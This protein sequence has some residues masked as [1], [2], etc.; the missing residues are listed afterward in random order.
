MVAIIGAVAVAR[1]HHKSDA[2]RQG[3]SSMDAAHKP[4]PSSAAPMSAPVLAQ[5]TK[6]ESEAST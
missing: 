6:I 3:V 1:G 2:T 5:V 4:S